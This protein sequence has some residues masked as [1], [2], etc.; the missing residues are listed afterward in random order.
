MLCYYPIHFPFPLLLDML[1]ERD[2]KLR[3]TLTLT[4]AL[5]YLQSLEANQVCSACAPFS[6]A[7]LFLLH[8]LPHPPLLLF[9]PGTLSYDH[10]MPLLVLTGSLHSLFL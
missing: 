6:T 8:P 7:D 2:E 4:P 3:I 1:V 9:W 10:V 5:H